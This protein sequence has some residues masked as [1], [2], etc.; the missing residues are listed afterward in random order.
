MPEPKRQTEVSRTD[1][2]TG[3]SLPTPVD[4]QLREA[5]IRDA[6]KAAVMLDRIHSNNYRR[7]DDMQMY[8]INV[9][10][11]KSAL[12]NIGETELSGAASRLEEA[13]RVKNI[14][15]ITEGTPEFLAALRK[16]IEKLKPKK[17]EGDTEGNISG[18][19]LSYLLE[20]LAVIQ[21]A[22]AEYDNKSA[23]DT[24]AQLREKTWPHKVM[25]L[26][27]TIAGH[28]L[29]SEFTQAS[30]LINDYLTA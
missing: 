27:N 24:L 23:K 22:C 1:Y 15:V 25:E 9:H 30:N 11:M 5:F 2:S 16:V 19:D 18:D 3:R 4:S 20:K 28:L 10:A 21:K 26:L 12:T 14:A 13:G 8:V 17:S 7:A 6:E 29:H